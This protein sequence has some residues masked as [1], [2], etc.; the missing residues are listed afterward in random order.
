MQ[1]GRGFVQTKINR[2]GAYY[3]RARAPQRNR[4]V[5]IT[6]RKIIKTGRE[7]HQHKNHTERR[8]KIKK[9][10]QLVCIEQ[11]A[12]PPTRPPSRRRL[13]WASSSAV[14]SLGCCPASDNDLAAKTSDPGSLTDPRPCHAPSAQ[15]SLESCLGW[16][17]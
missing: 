10:L 7:T 14:Y 1:C 6:C 13:A 15:H 17:C 5:Y 12:S 4:D 16:K 2:G 11:R 8:E 9:N 3:A